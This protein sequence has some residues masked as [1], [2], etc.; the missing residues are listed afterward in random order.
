MTGAELETM[1]HMVL[2]EEEIRSLADAVCL[3]QRHRKMDVVALVRALVLT[4]GTPGGGRQ[5]DALRAYLEQGAPNVVRGAFYAWFNEKLTMLLTQLAARACA[6][7]R[8]MPVHLPGPLAGRRD[9]RVIDSTVIM[10]TD[11]LRALF[12]GTGEYASLKIHKEY[13]LGVENVVDYHITPGRDHDGPELHVDESRRGTGLIVDLG[14]AS[15]KLVA[16]CRAHD[17]HLVMKLKSGWRVWADED[18]STR[19]PAWQKRTGLVGIGIGDRIPDT[20][21]GDID[22]DV[23]IGSDDAPIPLRLVGMATEK[24][25][26]FFLTTA[27]REAVSGDGVS[28][29]YRLR[30]C[31]ELDNKLAKSACRIDEIGAETNASALILVHSAMIA[32]VLANAVVHAEHVERGAVGDKIVRFK[33]PPLHGMLVAKM[34]AA[35]AW[36][37]AEMMGN[38]ETPSSAWDHVAKNL[39]HMGADPNWRRTPSVMDVVKGRVAAPKPR[40]KKARGATGHA[41]AN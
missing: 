15:H 20:V 9:W 37:V 6:Y 10:L 3:Q 12:P 18:L 13:S 25:Q 30:W 16:D 36:R 4:G 11:A 28:T 29:I 27:P 8:Q 21:K 24:G 40:P 23:T 2:P 33:K 35:S 38:P 39:H 7:A 5:A 41:A 1:L 19:D 31:I 26:I 17:V 22:I 32:S 14:Y 34:L